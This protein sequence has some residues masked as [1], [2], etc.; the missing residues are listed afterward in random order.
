M[1]SLITQGFG[2]QNTSG[3]TSGN[4]VIVPV[5]LQTAT[6]DT[7][8]KYITLVFDNVISHLLRSDGFSVNCNGYSLPIENVSKTSP[9][10]LV[11]IMDFFIL[12]N[13]LA[14]LSYKTDTLDGINQINNFLITNHSSNYGNSDET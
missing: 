2:S 8:G 13:R 11:I 14:Y 1:G 12:K 6:I 4:P 9:S 5:N 7:S 10:G 3:N